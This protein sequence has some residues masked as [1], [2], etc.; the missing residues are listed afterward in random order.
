MLTVDSNFMLKKWD[1]NSGSAIST[2]L[3]QRAADSN[4]EATLD[5]CTMMDWDPYHLAIADD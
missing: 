3:I 4:D 1:L 5:Y 2:L